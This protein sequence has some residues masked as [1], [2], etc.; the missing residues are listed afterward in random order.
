MQKLLCGLEYIHDK[1]F[2]HRNLNPG[3]IFFDKNSELKIAN[4]EHAR[5]MRA[6]YVPS[7]VKA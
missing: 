2:M 4:F 1:K 3:C 6:G 7:Q 5:M